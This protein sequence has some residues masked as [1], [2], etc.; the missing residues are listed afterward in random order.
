MYRADKRKQ[1]LDQLPDGSVL[2]LLSDKFRTFDK[3]FFYLTG[4]IQPNCAYVA[5]K[6][7]EVAQS[8]YV[9]AVDAYKLRWEGDMLTHG[10]AAAA[11]D[12]ADVRDIG[13]FQ[14][15]VARYLND[16]ST[17]VY[18]DLDPTDYHTLQPAFALQRELSE[19]Y[20]TL[21]WGNAYPLIAGLRVFKTPEEL[22]S[23]REAMRITANGIERMMRAVRPGLYEYQL[24]AE[25]EHELCANGVQ[26]PGFDTN[27]SG[28]DNVFCLHY[29]A[30]TGRI[31]DGDLVLVD[32]GAQVNGLCVD[33]SRVFPANG[34]FTDKQRQLYDVALRANKAA[35]N[36]VKPGVAFADI[37]S[38]VRRTVYEGLRDIG[39]VNHY[40]EVG[41]YYWHGV[42]HYVGLD[43]HDVGSYAQPVAPDMVFTIDAGIYVPEWH[44]G[45]RVE[46]DV[47]VTQDGYEWLSRDIPREVD[48]LERM[49][50]HA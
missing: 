44:I 47:L 16:P 3:N 28:G 40:D 42:A 37:E 21:H 29:N 4:V 10:Q 41:K 5:T 26:K 30:L 34:R 6:R 35:M 19:R 8:L 2:I 14:R 50:G 46:D 24:K 43:V 23:I 13:V 17:Q 27:V 33:I 48:A 22:D 49:I 12:V 45:L 39:L 25:F 7:G 18:M 36:V 15:D 9:P 20:P 1:L 31:G 38:T 11:S 32:V